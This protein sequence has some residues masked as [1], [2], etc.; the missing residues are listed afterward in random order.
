MRK[1]M[2]HMHC[3]YVS[4]DLQSYWHTSVHVNL[5]QGAFYLCILIIYLQK[6][7]SVSVRE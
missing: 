2:I 6:I 1:S 4:A 5:S 3:L 7:V